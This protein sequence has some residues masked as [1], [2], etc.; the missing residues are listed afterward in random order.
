MVE[1][2]RGYRDQLTGLLS[3]IPNWNVVGNYE[4]AS[5]ATANVSNLRPD[6]ILLDERLPGLNGTDAIPE[7]KKR[8]PHAKIMMLTVDDSPNTIVNALES[9][10][11][12]YL[13]KGGTDR[14]TI[15]AI[16]MFIDQ[17]GWMSPAV[18][19]TVIERMRRRD[20]QREPSD[21]GLTERQWKILQLIKKGK[22][23]GEVALALGIS[24]NT[25]KNHLQNIFEKLQVS[26]QMEALRKIGELDN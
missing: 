7:F 10:A 23:R 16:E 17:G 15:A 22:Q 5:I 12:G 9:G 14:E 3:S 1:D 4:D 8:A 25:V 18:A 13:L 19:L 2:D 11:N 21:F 20:Q 6:L 26:S 24:L